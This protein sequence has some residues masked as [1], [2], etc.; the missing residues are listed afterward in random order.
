M[1]FKD[2]AN[3]ARDAVSKNP[4]WVEKAG[5]VLDEKTDHKFSG[6]IDQ[7]QDAA[8]KWAGAGE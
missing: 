5:D 3:K 4:E 2:L 7:A 1:D 6:Q 8:K